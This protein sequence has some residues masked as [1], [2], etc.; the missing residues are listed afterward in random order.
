MSI[1]CHL[2]TLFSLLWFVVYVGEMVF[3]EKWFEILAGFNLRLGG[4][5]ILTTQTSLYLRMRPWASVFLKKT[6]SGS[7][8]KPGL[9]SIVPH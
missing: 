3:L 9:R 6:L 2:Q 1:F 7:N 4:N 8:M 5:V